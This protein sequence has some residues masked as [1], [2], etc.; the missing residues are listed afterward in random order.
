LYEPQFETVIKTTND[1]KTKIFTL[2]FFFLM[3]S[4]MTIAQKWQEITSVEE[5][6]K[7]YPNEMKKMLGEFNL[8]YP[9]MEKVKTAWEA[10]NLA[11]A[12][13]QLLEYY[14]NSD[15]A[16][17]LRKS[18]PEKSSQTEAE[19]DTILKN[20]FVIQNV[21]GQVPWG[22]DGHRDWYY[23]GP[24]NDRE[25]AWL[26]NRHSQLSHVF[27][28][29]LETGNP[30]YAEYIDLFL[31]DFIIKSMPYPAEKGGESIWRG[32]EVAARAKVWSR[33]F[34]G[35]LNS[36]YLTPAT[37]L[38]MLSSLP[39]HAHYNRNF[40]GGNN[41]L[42]ME[43][44]AIATIATNFPEYKKSEEW[45]DYSIEAMTESMKD[46]VYPDGVQTE[47]TSHYHNVS[48]S[49]FE[50]LKEICDRVNKPL[51][52]FF[53]QT[54][55]DMYSYIAHAVR[56]DGYR[57]LNN[58]GDRGS[59]RERILRGAEKF[60]KPDWE[61]IATNGQSGTKPT[62]GP[63]YFFPWAGHLISRNGFDKDAHW[64]FFDIG[65]W[66]S[67]HQHNDK[68][69]ISVAAY[70]RDLLVDAGR[71]AYTGEVAEKFRSYA[72]G[73]QGHNVLLI[74]GKGQGPGVPVTDEPVSKKHWLIT[75]EYDYAWSSFN[76]FN[77]LDGTCEHTRR[78]FYAR[79]DLW[80][81]VDQ[82]KTDRPRKIEALWHWHPDCKVVNDGE[83]VST[84]NEKG[85]L[86]VIPVGKQ[87]WK[88]TFAEGQE[89]PE[90]QGWYSEE[91]NKYEP[92]V[93]SIYST[94]I[95]S[96]SK[97]VWVLFPSEK[98]ET[99]IQAEIIS[100]SSEEIKIKVWNERNDQWVIDVPLN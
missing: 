87:D 70:G 66:G 55:A 58:D 7:A 94:N 92:N 42:T 89:E 75:G 65:P 62:D 82:V 81:V 41:W 64:S 90:I 12:C 76:K 27:N 36:E 33:I 86:Q 10:G 20:V 54:I 34:Y 29:Y 74:D 35:M 95:E 100:D 98:V 1:M 31:R 15:N 53:N 51:P 5:V 72:R 56:P 77:N 68:H 39:D 99:G 83:I 14:K 11:E 91:Y 96:D 19:A 24:N 97:L 16:N 43:M 17:H 26:S 45:L 63:S 61:Y 85:N 3:I 93:A 67:G 4:G 13:K 32:L 50:L 30:K 25:W 46:Q 60:N 49:N 79:G 88:I 47:L 57:I 6:C 9:G 48:L 78:L 37:R 21:R 23:K 52:D 8:E 38:L 28:V 2:I 73:S 84:Q 59:D 40:H 80:V 71:F 44:T 22:D 69:H 18:Q